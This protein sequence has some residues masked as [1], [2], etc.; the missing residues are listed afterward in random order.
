M[1]EEFD[2]NEE[3]QS[4]VGYEK[5][6]D[7][8]ESVFSLSSVEDIIEC[9]R[10]IEGTSVNVLIHVLEC[11][12]MKKRESGAISDNLRFKSLTQRYYAKN[13]RIE[14]EKKENTMTGSNKEIA[15]GS[16]I[17]LEM[18]GKKERDQFIVRKYV[19]TAVGEKFHNKW[20]LKNSEGNPK[21]PAQ[22]TKERKQYRFHAREIIRE[23]SSGMFMLKSYN[24]TVDSRRY[25]LDNEFCPFVEVNDMDRIKRVYGMMEL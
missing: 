18:S 5:A 4:S 6:L 21:W 3:T 14:G 1:T 19:I 12:N 11:M 22:S 13:E 15:R 8:L 9:T 7:E 20:F 10:M 2:S 16:I 23:S 24:T 25:P 17:D